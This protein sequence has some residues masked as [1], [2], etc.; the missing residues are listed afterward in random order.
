MCVCNIKNNLGGSVQNTT[1]KQTQTAG[2]AADNIPLSCS[3]A[4]YKKLTH[5]YLIGQS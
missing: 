1:M 5:N 4:R 3:W 2:H